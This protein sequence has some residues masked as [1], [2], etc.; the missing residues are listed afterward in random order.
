MDPQDPYKVIV[1][2]S[3]ERSVKPKPR[4]PQQ[5]PPIAPPASNA[6]AQEVD[7][8]YEGFRAFRGVSSAQGPGQGP[9]QGPA[10]A[11]TQTQAQA[12]AQ[13]P[14]PGAPQGRLAR[15][16]SYMQRQARS[17]PTRITAP[18]RSYTKTTPQKKPNL[19]GGGDDQ[20]QKCSDCPNRRCGRSP[21]Q[22]P[23]MRGGGGGGD[24]YIVLYQ[25]DGDRYLAEEELGDELFAREE[26]VRYGRTG[27]SAAVRCTC[28]R[29]SCP[30]HDTSLHAI[31]SEVDH[32]VIDARRQS[33]SHYDMEHSDGEADEGSKHPRAE[34]ATETDQVTA[35][36]FKNVNM[37]GGGG[38]DEPYGKIQNHRSYHNRTH[39]LS[40]QH[41]QLGQ[42]STSHAQERDEPE[43]T[44]GELHEMYIRI[45]LA[46]DEDVKTYSALLRKI[47]KAKQ[48]RADILKKA[49]FAAEA[50][51]RSL[52]WEKRH[53]R[54][55][56]SYDHSQARLRQKPEDAQIQ[57]MVQDED[58]HPFYTRSMEPGECFEQGQRRLGSS[59]ERRWISVPL[60]TTSGTRDRQQEYAYAYDDEP[61]AR[62]SEIPNLHLRG[63][64]GDLG[65]HAID[66]IEDF[67]KKDKNAQGSTCRHCHNTCDERARLQERGQSGNQQ[68]ETRQN[69]QAYYQDIKPGKS[70]AA[71]SSTANP[72]RRRA[73]IGEINAQIPR[74]VTACPEQEQSS[75]LVREDNNEQQ[76]DSTSAN[77]NA[78][79]SPGVDH[80]YAESSVSDIATMYSSPS[81]SERSGASEPQP[82]VVPRP[83]STCFFATFGE[84]ARA[85]WDRR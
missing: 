25:Y 63:G 50:E 40:R 84:Y 85:A 20:A 29:I 62:T 35:K 74:I 69:R 61:M 67:G 49:P 47:I 58:G 19:R 9:A 32:Y 60:S 14:A 30:R 83:S 37:R 54:E 22:Q 44:D 23:N 59:M 48:L 24:D 78:P 13:A 12:P 41:S 11:T 26:R 81:P 75:N 68:R 51:E 7:C 79:A 42:F 72:G 8:P 70:L 82:R 5:A 2:S 33:I 3:P 80:E 55:V 34:R 65:H 28:P 53:R 4:R 71:H 1:V 6:R 27:H 77:A 18:F 36:S 45:G 46:L 21:E 43:L 76:I 39:P 56:P 64:R 57:V 10:Q 17:I 16:A 66:D 31:Y 52:Q 73:I 15:T 38:G